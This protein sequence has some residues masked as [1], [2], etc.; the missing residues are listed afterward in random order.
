MADNE[1]K[2]AKG[3]FILLLGTFIFRIG[4]FLYRFLMTWLMTAADYGIL[5]LTLPFQN[6][7]N[8]TAS[9]GLPSAIAKYVAEYSALDNEQ[10]EQQVIRTSFKLIIIMAIIGATIMFLIA[11]P[12]A[13]GWW[14][15]P[16]AVLPL[17]LVAVITPF[18]VIVGLYRGVF[19][20]YY[21]M[22]NILITKAFEQLG[23]ICFAVLL[24]VIGWRVSGAVLGTVMGFLIASLSAIWLFKK[25]VTSKFKT[26]RKKITRAQEWDI[27][28]MLLKFSIPV[29][30]TGVAEVLLYDVGT[31]FIGA[32]LASNFAGYYTNASA[33]ARLPLIISMSVATSALP[34]ASEAF[35]LKDH[36]L[37]EKYI[38]QSYRYVIIVVLPLCV[39]VAVF[40][41]PIL[42]LLFGVEY[43]LGTTALQILV[44]GML[45]FAVYT[46]SSSI[47]QGLGKPLVPM[48]A[49]ILGVIIQFVL[50][51]FMVL[52]WNI[53]GAAL[54][55]SI[56]TAFIMV[57][58]IIYTHKV[59]NVKFETV[60][61][62]K[63]LFASLIMGLVC[64]FIPKNIIG[65]IIGFIVGIFVYIGS[66]VAVKGLKKGDLVLMY[67]T[68]SKLG[69][70]KEYVYKFTDKL[71]KYAKD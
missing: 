36:S 49:L 8:I 42:G 4:G 12:I 45:C 20:G 28:I 32:Y 58:C 35:S 41:Q 48:I 31:L 70:L 51:M 34:A 39:G 71:E 11:K 15:K 9:G 14:H 33:I 21:Q 13:L 47:T 63:I 59:S 37:L 24:V 69:P 30:I 19:Q 17:E 1:S 57:V 54:A 68:G 60:D 7:L 53:N 6:F 27:I 62:L 2:I 10:M 52:W 43:T 67:K 29:L 16:A 66:L 3:S 40:A 56:S 65:M 38:H 18:S 23:M 22:T 55:T 5:G 61:F 25:D 26:G 50:S 64:M 46:I 44:L